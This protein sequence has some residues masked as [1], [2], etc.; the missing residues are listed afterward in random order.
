MKLLMSSPNYLDENSTLVLRLAT[1][2]DQLYQSFS[3]FY[4]AIFGLTRP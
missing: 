2:K 3:P 4:E 1:S